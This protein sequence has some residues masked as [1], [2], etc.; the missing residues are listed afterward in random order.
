MTLPCLCAPCRS[1]RRTECSA[2]P[3]TP[4]PA[5]TPRPLPRAGP[6]RTHGGAWQRG[7]RCPQPPASVAAPAEEG[8]RT[9]TLSSG[10]P[11]RLTFTIKPRAPP[12]PYSE[13]LH[14]SIRRDTIT[15]AKLLEVAVPR[16]ADDAAPR[17]Q[18][19]LEGLGALEPYEDTLQSGH[20]TAVEALLRQWRL[21]APSQP[22]GFDRQC[23][24]TVP[25]VAG[26]LAGPCGC[27]A[28]P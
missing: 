16:A 4:A 24:L 13:A 19:Q 10:R 22:P 28:E 5:G 20:S 3:S 6:R 11:G 2:N 17:L 12:L 23:Q 1:R 21:D 18:Q 7:G 8:A 14:A 26:E 15:A 9:L 25:D 27:G